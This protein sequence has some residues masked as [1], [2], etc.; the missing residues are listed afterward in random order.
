MSLRA[1]AHQSLSADRLSVEYKAPADCRGRL[2]VWRSRGRTHLSAARTWHRAA[3]YP[4]AGE[5][6]DSAVLSKGGSASAAIVARHCSMHPRDDEQMSEMVEIKL[7][8]LSVNDDEY[9][10]VERLVEDGVEVAAG[11]TIAS[12]ESAKT[13]FEV[14]APVAGFVFFL[15]APRDQV[16][17]GERI[18]VISPVKEFDKARFSRSTE[19][20]PVVDDPIYS[21]FTAP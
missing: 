6:H 2:D 20:A 10:F 18:A 14:E 12:I 17:V 15:K 7:E 1:H 11:V 9:T 19:Q 8:R 16:A 13:V 4:P 3:K 5:R 21:K